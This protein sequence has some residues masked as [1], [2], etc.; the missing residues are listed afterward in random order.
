MIIKTETLTRQTKKEIDISFQKI[1][2]TSIKLRTSSA[3][4]RIDKLKKLKVKIK[5]SLSQIEKA[6]I[7]DLNKTTVET[8]MTEILPTLLELRHTIKHLREWM[9]PNHT[10]K[11]FLTLTGNGQII[12]EPKGA[13]LIIS[14]W[15]YPFQ[16]AMIPLISAVAAGNSVILRPSDISVNT[17]E[18]IKKIISETFS[19]NEVKVITGD[20]GVAE[21]LT[22]KQFDHIFFTGS[23]AVG[24]KVME[25]AARNLTPVTLE[26]GGK[27]PA[28]VHKSANIKDAA[29]KIAWGKMLNSGQTCI[30]P[31]YVIVDEKRKD[32]F[33]A[34]LSNTFAKMMESEKENLV[35]IISAKHFERIQRITK[36]SLRL[37]AKCL[38]GGRFNKKEKRIEPTI[39][40][41][42]TT[43][44][45]IMKEE[46]FG[47][48]LPIITVNNT[49]EAIEIINSR[50]KPLALYLFSRDRNKSDLII[51]QTSS[52]GGCIN[53]VIMHYSSEHLPF[54]GIG[55]SGTGNYHGYYGFKTFSHERSI[56]IQGRFDAKKLLYPPYTKQK[57]KLTK[58][59]VERV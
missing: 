37:G 43:E 18:C 16:L 14:P 39:L 15:N 52:G 3:S 59:I 21:Y 28:I 32:K 5:E 24:K 2:E 47:P 55:Q 51:K 20:A 7:D 57:E 23:T 56:F 40:T 42:V 44:M 50:P 54:G 6:L 8:N 22:T 10:P 1:K 29:R 48:I 53:D 26:L 4:E 17:T 46:I 58:F 34:Q 31:D 19:E 49:K 27:T 35:R 45:P 33:I 30:A 41:E 25:K 36:E 12:C 38:Y 13:V 9:K 11:T